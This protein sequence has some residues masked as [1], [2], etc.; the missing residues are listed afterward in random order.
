MLEA[1][2]D[3][4]VR[5]QCPQCRQPGEVFRR[6]DF[7]V[8]Q[9]GRG[10]HQKRLRRAQAAGDQR[11]VF[12]FST[13]YAQGDVHALIEQVDTPAGLDQF[14]LHLGVG[15]EKTHYQFRKQRDAAGRANP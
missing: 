5:F 7:G 10:G 2:V 9:Q 12:I 4:P 8:L 14:Q 13:A 6:A 1:H 15:R 11:G 3:V